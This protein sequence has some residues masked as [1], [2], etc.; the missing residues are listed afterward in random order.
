MQQEIITS[1]PTSQSDG[2]NSVFSEL[3]D[4]EFY[5]RAADYLAAYDT[6]NELVRMSLRDMR[7]VC[8]D[9]GLRNHMWGISPDILRRELKAR[10]YYGV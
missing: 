8:L 6:L 7:Q 1:L 2:I 10:G 4:A 5:E 3:S 9:F